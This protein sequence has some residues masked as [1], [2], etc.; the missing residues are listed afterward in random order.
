MQM[1]S[2]LL[3]LGG[4]GVGIVLGREDVDKCFR[5]CLPG[6]EVVRA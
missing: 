1:I 6:F 5:P 4:L 2:A 3:A